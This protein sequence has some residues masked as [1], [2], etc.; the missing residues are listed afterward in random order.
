MRN[1]G[2]YW[3]ALFLVPMV[4][5]FVLHRR[6]TR[7]AAAVDLDV[8]DPDAEVLAQLTEAGSD[9]FEERQL[10]F[11]LV[12]P[13]EGSAREAATQIRSMGFAAEAVSATPEASWVCMA[14]K[15]MVPQ[16]QTL[17]RLRTQFDAIAVSLGGEYD[18]WGSPVGE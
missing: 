11:Y 12:L 1:S 13:T 6:A 17:K 7:V 4:V 10:E 9:L 3:I 5:W 18:G 2:L 15:S 14:S 8:A 16:L